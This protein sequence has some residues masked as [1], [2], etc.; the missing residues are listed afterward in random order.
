MPLIGCFLLCR[1]VLHVSKCNMN[2]GLAD[3]NFQVDLGFIDLYTG[4]VNV[5][6]DIV[7]D[8]QVS[9]GD[10]IPFDKKNMDPTNSFFL[11]NSTFV[12]PY[13]ATFKFMKTR[14]R[15]QAD[16]TRDMYGHVDDRLSPGS[17]FRIESEPTGSQKLLE[18]GQTVV[19]YRDD[20]T[21][22]LGCSEN[23]PC[24]VTIKG[25]Q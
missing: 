8:H 4:Q 13:K 14:F 9:R 19:F 24:R 21:I 22:T 2:L 3:P 6:V 18:K 11:Q 23:D 20:T 16:S 17:V 10:V 7:H 12:A 5:V 1:P 15:C 25:E